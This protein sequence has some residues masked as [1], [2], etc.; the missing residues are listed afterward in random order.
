MPR[1][2]LAILLLSRTAAARAADP[3][4]LEFV[5]KRIRP[6]LAEHCYECHGPK[7]QNAGLRLDQEKTIRKGGDNGPVIVNG[8]P[9]DSLLIHAV[10][11]D[12]ASKMP[13]KSPLPPQARAH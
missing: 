12:G 3:A 5:E 10:R 4:E 1:L 9:D 6:V 13:P 7:K 8:K 11:R 2:G